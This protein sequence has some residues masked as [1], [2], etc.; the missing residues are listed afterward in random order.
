VH[1]R[2]ERGGGGGV[3]TVCYVRE[4]IDGGGG[5]PCVVSFG[6]WFTEKNFV[7]HFPIFYT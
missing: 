1:E 2:L 6:K 5:Y 3:V 7:N 4:R